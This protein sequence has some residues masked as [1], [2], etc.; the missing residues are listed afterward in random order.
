M[1]DLVKAIP[2]F[3]EYAKKEGAEALAGFFQ[4]IA[5]NQAEDEEFEKGIEELRDRIE[6]VNRQ[7]LATQKI[8][9]VY[10]TEPEMFSETISP[11]LL[12]QTSESLCEDDKMWTE[13]LFDIACRV[14]PPQ[15][16]IRLRAVLITTLTILAQK[17]FEYS[18]SCQLS[19]LLFQMRLLLRVR[20]EDSPEVKSHKLNLVKEY[21]FV[22][23]QQAKTR[24]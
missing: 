8:S 15:D 10:T 2:F 4:F 19:A 18:H 12:V 6:E 23:F 16:S 3:A 1:S 20:P 14:I 5:N 7:K 24:L 9:P 21:E 13:K 11:I 22:S 17:P